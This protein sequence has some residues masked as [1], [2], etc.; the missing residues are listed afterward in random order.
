[1][2]GSNVSLQVNLCDMEIK[3]ADVIGLDEVMKALTM[4]AAGASRV[5]RTV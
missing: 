2:D 1:M 4:W 5:T 3:F